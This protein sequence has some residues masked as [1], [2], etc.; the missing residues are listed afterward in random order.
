MGVTFA[1]LWERLFSSKQYK[2]CI[3]GLD[4]AGKT[5]LLYKL[6]LGRNFREY[7][8]FRFV[9]K[10][11]RTDY[12]NICSLISSSTGDVVVAQPTIGSNVEEITYKNIR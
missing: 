5:S 7:Y 6:H 12:V 3:I 2:L 10:L 11:R 9:V 8:P 4:N 1:K